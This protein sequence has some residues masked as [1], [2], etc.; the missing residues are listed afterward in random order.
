[1]NARE[2]EA[3]R[4]GEKIS[5]DTDSDLCKIAS[6]LIND[7]DKAS[8][9]VKTIKQAVDIEGPLWNDT[10]FRQTILTL[11]G[12]G[13]STILAKMHQLTKMELEK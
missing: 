7:R 13:M 12:V 6:E 3:H 4:I 5:T 9:M 2:K 1:M 11:A 8:F 10:S